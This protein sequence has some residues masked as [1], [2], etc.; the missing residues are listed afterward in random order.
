V[1]LSLPV[2]FLVHFAPN[3]INRT[4]Q[5][6]GSRFTSGRRRGPLLRCTLSLGPW[7]EK[8]CG[9]GWRPKSQPHP[10]ERVGLVG[11]KAVTQQYDDISSQISHRQDLGNVTGGS[12]SNADVDI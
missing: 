2:T 3:P 6:E 5:L 7:L 8:G 1:K 9:G 10:G 4:G 12:G 11:Q